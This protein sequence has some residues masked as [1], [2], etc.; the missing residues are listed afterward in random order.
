MTIP[1]H[2]IRSEVLIK[3]SQTFSISSSLLILLAPN[4]W[5]YFY[6]QVIEFCER[7]RPDRAQLMKPYV[8]PPVPNKDSRQAMGAERPAELTQAS[9]LQT[10]TSG[11]GTG[12]AM[13]GTEGESMNAIASGS[14]SENTNV[15][16]G[17]EENGS[18]GAVENESTGANET[19]STRA[20]EVESEAMIGTTSDAVEDTDGTGLLADAPGP[21]SLTDVIYFNQNNQMPEP[22]KDGSKD[23]KEKEKE[24]AVAPSTEAE[25]GEV[26]AMVPM[27]SKDVFEADKEWNAKFITVSPQRSK[28]LQIRTP[29]DGFLTK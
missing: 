11:G 26:P 6:H 18:N 15:T 10:S 3:V 23:E 24:T 8:A 28:I 29:S 9:S 20:V 22:E 1:L 25:E 4:A 13:L 7:H 2:N 12:L 16:D 19:G 5:A 27:D 14:G 21:Y 17:T